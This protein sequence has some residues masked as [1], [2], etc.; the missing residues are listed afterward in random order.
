MAN[1]PDETSTDTK[2]LKQLVHSLAIT[3]LCAQQSLR[4]VNVDPQTVCEQVI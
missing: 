1:K 3:S 4:A 2:A